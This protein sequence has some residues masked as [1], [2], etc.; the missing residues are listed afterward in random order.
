MRTVLPLTV[1]LILWI[2]L[3]YSLTAREGD[4]LQV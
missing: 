2:L 4:K 1:V 3:L